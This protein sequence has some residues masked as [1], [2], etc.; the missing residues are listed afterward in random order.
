MAMPIKARFTKLDAKLARTTQTVNVQFN[1][2]E[3][4]LNKAA[5]LA[6]IAIPGLDAP[7]IQF[8]R[9][10]TETLSL[11]L[12]F[13]S[14]EEDARMDLEAKPV[15]VKTDA[16]YQLIKIERSTHAIPVLLLEWGGTA[17]PGAQLTEEWVSQSRTAFQC[18]VES[19]RQK[20][21]L[22]NPRG[23]PLRAT[24]TVQL[25][26]YKSLDQQVRELGL[27]SP[28]HTHAHVVVQGDTLARIAERAYGESRHWRAIARHNGIVNPL[29][30]APGSTLEIPPI[31]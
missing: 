28:D 22:F 18:V 16:F 29:L 7:L 14:T 30:L 9:G 10:Q 19:V 4:T 2:T 17:F 5:Q 26:E 3:F 21:T 20:F 13:D 27:E 11:D 6:E 8:V 15:T 23:A 31:R 12:Y 1:P 25:K 24:L